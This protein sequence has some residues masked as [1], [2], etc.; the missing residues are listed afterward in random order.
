MEEIYEEIL[1]IKE[2]GENA[3]LA[4]IISVKGSTPREEG[5]KML[6]KSDGTISGSIGGGSLEGQVITKAV[7]I[8]KEGGNPGVLKFDLTGVDAAKEGMICGGTMEVF[9]EPI[10]SAPNL[11][12]FGG[13]HIS[14]TLAKMAKMVGFRITVIDDR[15]SFANKD[16][17]PEADEIY[18]KDFKV[19]LTEIKPKKP[20]YIV[21]VTR[22]HI[23]DEI[24]LE[25]AVKKEPAYIGMIGSR[26]KNH[27]VFS[28]LEEKGIGKDRLSFVHAPIGI[29]IKAQTPEEI[30]VSILAEL[31]KIK[32]EV[33]GPKKKNWKV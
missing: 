15:D 3:V 13:G 32:R 14:L 28:H 33:E 1:K 19:I 16:R 21:I 20:Y 12:I 22:G 11:Y 9:L 29:D 10:M 25:W 27:T 26:S 5:S 31:I 24:V 8:I 23:H 7:R 4:T 17:F 6:I 2:K 30:S 18:A